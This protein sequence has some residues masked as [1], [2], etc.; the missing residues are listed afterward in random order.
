MT[1]NEFREEARKHEVRLWEIA[2]EAG[3]SEPTI[4]R[5]LRGRLSTDRE[6]RLMAAL[7]NICERRS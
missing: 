4:I 1:G 7:D 2:Q 6:K 5:W 3:I